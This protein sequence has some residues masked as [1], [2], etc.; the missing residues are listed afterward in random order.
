MRGFFLRFAPPWSTKA[1]L[2]P[3][4]ELYDLGRYIY[5]LIPPRRTNKAAARP[6][7]LSNAFEAIYRRDLSRSGLEKQAGPYVLKAS[8]RRPNPRLISINYFSKDYKTAL[9]R[10]FTKANSPGTT[11]GGI[12][13]QHS[14]SKR[15]GPRI[16]T[17]TRS[18]NDGAAEPWETAAP[19]RTPAHG[20][21]KRQKARTKRGADHRKR[22]HTTMGVNK[23]QPGG[24]HTVRTTRDAL[25]H[26]LRKLHG[27]GTHE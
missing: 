18:S 25:M 10:S 12:T 7:W 3:W 9:S 11:L 26:P 17:G 6:P 8:G 5:L 13:T 15:Q 24:I 16:N 21:P 20:G 1:A 14:G 22:P 4:R 23:R 19:T 27:R 2:P